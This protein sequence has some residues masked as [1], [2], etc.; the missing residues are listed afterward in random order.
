VLQSR[1]GLIVLNMALVKDGI[2]LASFKQSSFIG[3]SVGLSGSCVVITHSNRRVAVY[4]VSDHKLVYDW[5]AKTGQDATCPAVELA[6]ESQFAVV[7]NNQVLRVWNHNDTLIDKGSKTKLAQPAHQLFVVGSDLVILFK[8]GS[9]GVRDRLLYEASGA[10]TD[11]LEILWC[12]QSKDHIVAVFRNKSVC[13]TNQCFV[14]TYVIEHERV[15]VS[16]NVLPVAK[17]E[18]QSPVTF[19]LQL[20]ESDL[21]LISVFA[22]GDLRQT[23]LTA[24]SSQPQASCE[25]LSP[26]STQQFGQILSVAALDSTQL[27]VV[28][29]QTKGNSA[30]VGI[31]VWDTKFGIFHSW[32]PL[33]D[34]KQTS[35]QL[36]YTGGR[37]LLACTGGVYTFGVIP[38]A[39]TLLSCLGKTSHGSQSAAVPRCSVEGLSKKVMKSLQLL[40]QSTLT[41]T[42]TTFQSEF[43]IL[44]DWLSKCSASEPLKVLSLLNAIVL[45]CIGEK[46]FWPRPELLE[47]IQAKLVTPSVCVQLCSTLAARDDV[48]ALL[49]CLRCINDIPEAAI[50]TCISCFLSADELKLS[51]VAVNDCD[52]DVV[53]IDDLAPVF[54]QHRAYCIN[55][56]LALP[57][58]DVFLLEFLHQLNYTQV[59]NLIRHLEYLL[60]TTSAAEPS[61]LG[62]PSLLQVMD[63]LS[64]LIDAHYPQ[65]VLSPDTQQLHDRLQAA[66]Q[67][68]R[69]DVELMSEIDKHL[70]HIMKG[71]KIVEETVGSYCIKMLH[72]D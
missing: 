13:S 50:V 57:Y 30:N 21:H 36:Y 66:L 51:A 31:G 54:N 44:R 69:E 26:V 20:T 40:S 55:R 4:N 2:L 22:N 60:Y 46:Q 1:C 65:M 41:P 72:I 10:N 59:L 25:V 63:W 15:L 17:S 9:I 61:S 48:D 38:R 23:C 11:Q 34:T 27:V 67:L 29:S 62:Q 56:V 64:L 3:L 49:T 70:L 35:G 42:Y 14:R 32:L 53:V 6:A 16:E 33:P 8:D 58:N 52:F 24:E 71:T 68:Q 19:C 5:L 37:L 28:G 12:S 45:R 18:M 43:T 39:A 7:I 47:L